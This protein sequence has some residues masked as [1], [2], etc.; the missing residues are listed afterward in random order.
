MFPHCL[1]Y[2]QDTP[3]K[4]SDG[5]VRPKLQRTVSQLYN[6]TP[7]SVVVPK[8]QGSVSWQLGIFDTMFLGAVAWD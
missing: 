6:K 7:D 8:D 2:L 4:N 3:K 5:T 1:Y